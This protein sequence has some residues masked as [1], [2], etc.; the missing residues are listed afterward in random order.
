MS[1]GEDAMQSVRRNWVIAGIVLVLVVFS[2][3]FFI[4]PWK[5]RVPE[6]YPEFQ[7]FPSARNFDPPGTVFRI[8]PDGVRFDVVDISKSVS[9][10]AGEEAVPEQTGSRQI[11]ADAF[12]MALGGQASASLRGSGRYAVVLK[13]AGVRRE[14]TLDFDVDRAL[15]SAL[16]L[17]ALRKDSKYFIIRETI[18]ASQINFTLSVADS[19]ALKA[20]LGDQAQAETKGALDTSGS[21][22]LKLVVKFDLPSRIFYKPEEINIDSSGISEEIKLTRVPVTQELVWRTE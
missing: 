6:L 9:P 20:K 1:G 19:A 21:G 18:A 4:A 8:N 15:K 14:K 2:G 13:L 5:P 7:M 16:Q 3:L 11:S 17:V 10:S 12:A 22:E